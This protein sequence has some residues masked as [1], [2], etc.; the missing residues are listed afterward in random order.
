[1]WPITFLHISSATVGLI[2]GALS[3]IF[4]KGSG[5][6]RA[7]GSVFVASMLTM[8]AA[9]V[10]LAT[11]SKPNL[12]NALGG[13]LAFYLVATAWT[14]GRRKEKKIDTFDRVALL[15]I[16]GVAS[17]EATCAYQAASSPTGAKDGYSAGMFLTLGIIALL[18]A[19]SDVRMIARGG[20]AGTPRIARH[21]WR[22]CLALLFALM[23][24]YPSR[25]RLFPQALN[26]SHL[27]Y[28]PHVLLIGSMIFWRVRVSARKR[29][30]RRT[31]TGNAP[32]ITAA[33]A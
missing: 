27:L 25:A 4:R 12:G 18:F 21:L 1:M 7:A 22:M 3:M 14:A 24:L 32:A 8:S 5:L 9:G 28:I 29:R 31:V 33:A 16:L 17:V 2:A 10:Y 11:F 30:Q 6:H 13:A 15:L 20:V 23:S 19:A 26:D